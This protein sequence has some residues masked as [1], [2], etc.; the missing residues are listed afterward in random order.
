MDI[1]ER[2]NN[3]IDNFI[4]NQADNNLHYV[5]NKLLFKL[6]L[7]KEYF[8][9]VLR[10]CMDHDVV[11]LDEYNGVLDWLRDNK[12]KGLLL[13]GNCG[14]GKSIIT[15][16]AIPFLFHRFHNLIFST[17]AAVDITNLDI[18][19]K[20][21]KQRL[22]VLD[23]VGTESKCEEFSFKRELFPDIVDAAEQ[24]GSL[25]IITTN[26]AVDQIV[27]RYGIRT[28]DR[29]VEITKPIALDYPSMRGKSVTNDT[30]QAEK[31][32][33]NNTDEQ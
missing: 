24:N 16:H 22:V 4:H 15:M 9:G 33:A 29:L 3:D 13:I 12:G 1:S 30:T 8:M 5:R 7:S 17:Y 32:K 25:L 20:I 10:K 23:D 14:V 26:L 31:P 19:S 21:R 28:L 27:E 2:I 18:Y 6:N 11:Y